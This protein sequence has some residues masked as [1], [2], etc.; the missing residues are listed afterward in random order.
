[1]IA[2]GLQQL[3]PAQISQSGKHPQRKKSYES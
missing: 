2:E 1:M 3:D